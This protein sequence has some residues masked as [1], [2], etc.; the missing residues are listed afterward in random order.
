V[1]EPAP[2]VGAALC[3]PVEGRP[4][5]WRPTLRLMARRQ[6]RAVE[7][8]QEPS[9][10]KQNRQAQARVVVGVVVIALAAIAVVQ[11]SQD[12]TI[13]F[14]AFTGHLGL[15]WAILVCLI[16]GAVLGFVVGR[17]GRGKPRRPSRR[18]SA[19]S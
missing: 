18:H 9:S 13:R 7:G 15:I 6:P 14:L 10:A 1:E 8:E 5:S 11:N 2:G 3:S 4:V 19:E 17:R 16:F 12:V